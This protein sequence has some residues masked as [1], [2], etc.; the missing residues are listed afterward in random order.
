MGRCLSVKHMMSMHTKALT[1]Q[2]KIEGFALPMSILGPD[3]K[4]HV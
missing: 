2:Q 3:G 1:M 4:A